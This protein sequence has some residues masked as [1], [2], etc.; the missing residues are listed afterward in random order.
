M[1]VSLCWDTGHGAR[2]ALTTWNWMWSEMRVL[3]NAGRVQDGRGARCS[4]QLQ[5]FLQGVL[6][7][8]FHKELV[9]L[10]G[11]ATGLLANKRHAA[12]ALHA[13]AHQA[14]QPKLVPVGGRITGQGRAGPAPQLQPHC[15]G[16]PDSHHRSHFC[17]PPLTQPTP[18]QRASWGMP[19]RRR[20]DTT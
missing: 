19:L 13:P 10:R 18:G 7:H 3:R 15:S 9:I 1:W 8:R 5:E 4:G 2:T 12:R 20:F 14:A 11:E 16:V 6:F 17:R